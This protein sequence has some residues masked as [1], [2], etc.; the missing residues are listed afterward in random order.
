MADQFGTTPDRMSWVVTLFL[1]TT[2]AFLLPLGKVSDVHGRRR[3]Y[4]VSLIMLALT[5][6]AAALAPTLP[7]LIGLRALQGI[8]L[9]GI[10]VSYMPLLLATTD[11]SR[12]GHIIGQSVALTYLGLSL[13]PVIGGAVTEF[14]GWRCI[15]I[16]AALLVLLSYLLIRPVKA[17]WYE[18]GA[19]FVNAI[20]SVL[21]ISAIL[22]TLY[23]LSSF[24]DNSFFFYAGLVL[25]VIFVVHEGRSFHPLL[26][27]YLF[28]SLTFSMSNLA[29]L[30]Q[31]SATYAVSFLLSLY[32]QVI[33][34]LTP[35][36]SGAVLLIQPLVMALLSPRAGDLSDTYGPRG[37]ASLGLFLTAPGL[38]V[39]AVFPDISIGQTALCLAVIGMGAALFGAP[40]NSAIMGSVKKMH[41]GIASSVL[42]LSRNL[43]QA[44]SMAAVTFIMTSETSQAAV[45]KDGVLNTL[46]I[47]F[48]LLSVLCFFAALASLARGRSVQKHH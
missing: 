15:F 7:I 2:A 3:T 33:L 32:L 27:L 42:A 9:A 36:V 19:P 48:I 29:A 47:A 17:E 23:G 22:C 4:T 6:I 18:N 1:M 35:A 10:Y 21:S 24:S 5:S 39:F 40:N 16:L 8:A 45:Y 11:E 37:I 26:P 41:H 20:S 12:Q 30:I 46:H 14:I 13:G 31:Y 44:F 28:R 25:S 34:G 38:L 43:G